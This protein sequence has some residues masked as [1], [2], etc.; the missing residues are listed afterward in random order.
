LSRCALQ[1]GR[2]LGSAIVC[3][4]QC[5]RAAGPGERGAG[6]RP[7]EETHTQARGEGHWA[8]GWGTAGSRARGVVNL[9]QQKGTPLTCCLP[10][11]AA[12][13]AASASS[14]RK[15]QGAD[16]GLWLF[17][18]CTPRFAHLRFMGN[19]S[20]C[21]AQHVGSAANTWHLGGYYHAGWSEFVQTCHLF[22]I[23]RSEIAWVNLGASKRTLY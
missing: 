2:Q 9:W 22:W 1:A 18:G 21:R 13:G 8:G 12:G 4:W 11:A 20:S 23:F 15:F 19:V 7:T 5:T 16:A 6:K 10:G 17:V 3:V 14:R